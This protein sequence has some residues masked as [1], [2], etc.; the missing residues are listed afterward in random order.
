MKITNYFPSDIKNIYSIHTDNKKNHLVVRVGFDAG[1]IYI[2][3]MSENP[4]IKGKEDILDICR[5]IVSRIDA[6]AIFTA[7]KAINFEGIVVEVLPKYNKCVSFLDS[8]EVYIIDNFD[9]MK[10]FSTKT[11]RLVENMD[12]PDY[13]PIKQDKLLIAIIMGL[14]YLKGDLAREVNSRESII[15]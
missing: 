1:N 14:A 7:N 11:T 6:G 5:N 13:I 15:W 4:I 9:L 2:E 12:N 3:N 10:V 8:S